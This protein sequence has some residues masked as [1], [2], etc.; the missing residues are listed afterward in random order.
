M[1]DC[2]EY[3]EHGVRVG[4]SMFGLGVFTLRSFSRREVIG[5]ILG[6]VID[7][8]EYGSDYCMALG[9][10]A[11]EPDAPFRFLNHSC[12]P[13]CSLLEFEAN[14]HPGAAELWLAIESDIE[15]GEQLTIDYAWPAEDAVPCGCGTQGCRKWIVAAEELGQIVIRGHANDAAG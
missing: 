9:N 10:S 5:P 8:R 1:D 4:D 7:D 11:L 3:L 2:V 6:L 13:N 12:R 14:E 15:P